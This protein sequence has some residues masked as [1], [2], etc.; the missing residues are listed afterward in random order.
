MKDFADSLHPPMEFLDIAYLFNKWSERLD[1]TE[2]FKNRSRGSFFS[3]LGENWTYKFETFLNKFFLFNNVV[4]TLYSL[5]LFV[6]KDIEEK[7]LSS[8]MKF[9]HTF[10]VESGAAWISVKKWIVYNFWPLRFESHNQAV[11]STILSKG[12][13]HKR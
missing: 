8:V 2:G 1:T 9:L 7:C 3:A 12:N 5:M 6:R 11:K 4:V 13:R 10:F